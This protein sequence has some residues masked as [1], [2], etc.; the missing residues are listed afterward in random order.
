MYLGA[1]PT[2]NRIRVKRLIVLVVS[3]N[4]AVLLAHA[5]ECGSSVYPVGVDTVL[6]GTAPQ[7]DGTMFVSLG[8]VYQANL[9]TDSHGHN[10]RLGLHLRAS[11][12]AAKLFHNWGVHS[13]G[14]TITPEADFT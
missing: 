11:V 14:G 3:F 9:L 1:L 4:S 10:A 6:S 8:V 2:Y 7:P 12:V 5:A 13:P